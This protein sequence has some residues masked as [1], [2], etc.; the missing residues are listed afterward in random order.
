MNEDIRKHDIF[1]VQPPVTP[2]SG[3]PSE[4]ADRLCTALFFCVRA[5]AGDKTARSELAGMESSGLLGVTVGADKMRLPRPSTKIIRGLEMMLYSASDWETELAFS[6]FEAA[7]RED[8]VYSPIMRFI[9]HEYG[10]GTEPDHSAAVSDMMSA[11][12]AR[13]PVQVAKLAAAIVADWD[14]EKLEDD[15]PEEIQPAAQDASDTPENIPDPLGLASITIPDLPTEPQFASF[16]PEPVCSSI[17][18]RELDDARQTAYSQL[19]AGEYEDSVQTLVDIPDLGEP[20]KSLMLGI[21]HERGLSGIAVSAAKAEKYL[22]RAAEGGSPEAMAELAEMYSEDGDSK[23]AAEAFRYA[24]YS[25][26]CGNAKGAYLLS[27]QYSSQGCLEKALKW[28]SSAVAF[29]YPA[30]EYEHEKLKSTCVPFL[31]K[32]RACYEYLAAIDLSIHPEA[33][34]PLTAFRYRYGSELLDHGSE[35]DGVAHIIAAAKGGSSEAM[36]AIADLFETGRYFPRDIKKAAKWREKAAA[37][38]GGV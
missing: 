34:G 12:T 27:R 19:A 22:R 30:D 2:L 37:A 23:N 24:Y 4:R 25:A 16:V 29:G 20:D 14:G 3:G 5:A 33:A 9:C 38:R 35:D 10:I 21:I 8:P 1:S 26:R 7:R 36:D 13:L 15:A 18:E 28:M 11:A 17:I 6:E 32:L 31:E